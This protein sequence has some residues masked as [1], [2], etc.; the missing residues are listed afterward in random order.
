MGGGCATEDRRALLDPR[1]SAPRPT[2]GMPRDLCMRETMQRSACERP[3]PCGRLSSSSLW[4]GFLVPLLLLLLHAASWTPVDSTCPST[5]FEP[6]GERNNLSLS[7]SNGTQTVAP[8]VIPI[9]LLKPNTTYTIGLTGVPATNVTVGNYTIVLLG[10]TS[11]AFVN[12][13]DSPSCVNLAAGSVAVWRSPDSRETANFSVQIS[14]DDDAVLVSFNV[15]LRYRDG[16]LSTEFR[17]ATGGC[18]ACKQ[19]PAG[20]TLRARCTATTDARSGLTCET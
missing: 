16:C 8:G 1:R 7:F 15:S 17:N 5:A 12:S 18:R 14:T 20:E 6:E 2:Q 13:T 3:R 11:G 4:G 10:S 19:C 9:A